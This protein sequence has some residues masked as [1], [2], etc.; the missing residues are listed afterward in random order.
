MSNEIEVK[1][2]HY[3]LCKISIS[4]LF[5]DEN[6]DY[7]LSGSIRIGDENDG[8]ELRIQLTKEQLYFI[9]KEFNHNILDQIST[10]IREDRKP[11]IKPTRIIICNNCGHDNPDTKNNRYCSYC[12]K[13]IFSEVGDDDA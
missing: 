3:N 7:T 12:G 13:R 4:A 11:L 9:K 5:E 6:G 10:R 2:P 8:Y 1:L